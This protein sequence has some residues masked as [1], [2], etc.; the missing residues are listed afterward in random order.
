[1][2]GLRRRLATLGHYAE[3]VWQLSRMEVKTRY[4]QR[5]LSYLW[6]VLEPMLLAATFFFLVLV[7]AGGRRAGTPDYAEMFMGLVVWNWFRASA[8]AGMTALVAGAGIIKQIRFPPVLLFLARVLTE[9]LGFLSSLGLVVIV[10]LAFGRPVLPT[11]VQF[12][13][14]LAVQLLLALAVGI[15]LSVLGV[16]VRDTISFINFVFNLLMYVS[17]IVYREELVPERY[18]WLLA[19]NPFTTLMRVYRN[20]LIDGRPI[21]NW[22]A[23]LAWS[24]VFAAVL[25][26]GVAMLRAVHRKLYRFL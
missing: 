6:W 10:L 12:P 17:P 15:W 20:T 18:R 1:V 9:A 26:A 8:N 5:S 2:T 25:A 19:W 22:G 14:G 16:F 11:W 13:V 7:L 23:L 24:L 21:D 3:I 4:F